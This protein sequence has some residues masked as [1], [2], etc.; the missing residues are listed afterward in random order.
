MFFLLSQFLDFFLTPSNVL[1]LGTLSAL[2]FWILRFR[3]IAVA[4]GMA[5]IVGLALAA[6]SPVGPFA[7]G[8]LENRFPKAALPED[9]AGIIVLGGAVDTHISYDRDALVLNEAGERIVEARILAARYPEA[10]IFLSGGGGHIFDDGT[11]TES[12]LARRA[13]V[14]AGVAGERITMEEL[15][16]NTCENARETASVL[17]KQAE[18][19]WILVTSASHMPRAVACFRTT[20]LAVLPYP[21]DYRTGPAGA[22]WPG[23][24]SSG[25]TTTD[26]AAH[27]W[28]GLVSYRLAG[29]TDVLFPSPGD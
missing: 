11:L 7:L 14:D 1:L 21:V 17:G 22:Y 19:T 18:G 29:F 26:L 28:I 5:S 25:L 6:W 9:V 27:E 23:T 10:D 2:A 13:L 20:D 8:V 16:R 12:E 24:A 4:L 15:S 3:K